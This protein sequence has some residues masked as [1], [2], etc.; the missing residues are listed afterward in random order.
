MAS[1]SARIR[2]SRTSADCDWTSSGPSAT[3]ASQS[4]LAGNVGSGSPQEMMDWVHYCNGTLDTTLVRERA[5]NGHTDSMRIRY[6][7]VG[8]ENWS[9][10]GNYD[11]EDYAKEFRRYAT[12]LRMADS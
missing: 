1:G 11:P 4:S 7:G 12:F 9:C 2:P 5:S 6:W 10:G 3:S 8:N